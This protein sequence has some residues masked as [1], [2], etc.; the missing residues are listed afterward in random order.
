MD[1]LSKQL[2]YRQQLARITRIIHSAP[3]T[4]TLLAQAQDKICELLDAERIT[5]YAS[6]PKTNL[7]R[8]VYQSGEGLKSIE[9]AVNY[10]S[11]AGYVALTGEPANVLD[12]YDAQALGA[13]H[14]KL[15]FDRRWDEASGFKTKQVL[16]VP[17]KFEGSTY[18]ALQLVNATDASGFTERDVDAAE[19][20]AGTLAI[21]LFN[22][23]RARSAG[24][25]SSPWRALIDRNRVSEQQLTEAASLARTE[26]RSVAAV[27]MDH[28]H[29]PRQEI[30]QALSQF[31]GCTFFRWDGNQSVPD[32]LKK[33][34]DYESLKRDRFAPVA[35]SGRSVTVVVDNPQDLVKL[36]RIR[37]LDLAPELDVWVGIPE[38]ISSCID[39]S[40]GL[41]VPD[42]DEEVAG[43]VNQ[44]TP[45]EDADPEAGED[46]A[47]VK[48]VNQVIQR[49]WQLGASDIHVEPNG[50]ERPVL[51][52][53]RVDGACAK[54][55]EIPAKARHALSS[56]IK[57]L[58]G[59]D[60]AERRKPQDG[61]IRFR[62]AKGT[63]EL[64]VAVVPTAGG[65]DLVLRLLAA[66][67]PVPLEEMALSP[68]NLAAFR[69]AINA[70]Y[71][72]MLVVGPTGSGKTTTLH[73]A[74][75][76]IN[77]P[78][79]KIWTAEDPVE[80]T[81]PGLRQVQV[82]PKIG[83]DFAAAMRAFLRADPDVIMVGEIRDPETA[84]T[85]VEASL[86]GHLV[87]STLH[88]NTAPE[89]VVR[90][91]DLGVDP[92]NFADAMLG[93]M[94]QRLGRT[95]CTSCRVPHE[96]DDSE[97]AELARLYGTE[98]FASLGLKPGDGST[99]Y[100]AKGCETCGSNGYKGRVALHEFLAGSERMRAAIQ[101]RATAEELR[102]VGKSEGMTTLLQDGIQKVLGGRTDLKQVRAVCLR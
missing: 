48:L 66:S 95:L 6:D 91:I 3:D 69:E 39:R 90:L 29:V 100:R 19:E 56:R 16:C 15:A 61:K 22:Q 50:D 60:I 40:F 71:G 102:E 30:G 63:L 82:H 26:Q 11:L 2:E 85:A 7:L 77:K 44:M 25:T 55:L 97:F 24:R 23:R 101:E 4:D 87:L 65:E 49:A 1:D 54:Q 18:G 92:F 35:R 37:S 14:P 81:Q 43:V 89:T 36:D 86:T 38:D 59:L 98:E 8:S 75:A 53:M 21:A 96:P 72:M 42:D 58:A 79:R 64:R 45:D 13:V 84:G 99:I 9:V 93:I 34:V 46:S 73:S 20:L 10:R 94:A 5:I 33:E 78:D 70:P 27:L 32:D 88:T 52:R 28:L 31:H 68:R 67:K 41:E 74:L 62:T 57:I 83:F 76:E 17:L 51:I 47:I 80:I 12:A